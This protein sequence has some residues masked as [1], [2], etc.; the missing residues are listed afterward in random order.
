MWWG[1]TGGRR[2]LFEPEHH[3]RHRQLKDLYDR[4]ARCI[5]AQDAD[6]QPP[7]NSDQK[8]FSAS[9]VLEARR[10]SGCSSSAEDDDRSSIVHAV[11]PTRHDYGNLCMESMYVLCC[12]KRTKG[13]AMSAFT[14]A[15]QWS[16]S[17]VQDLQFDF[18]HQQIQSKLVWKL[19]YKKTRD[20]CCRVRNDH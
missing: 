16:I 18:Y 10:D 5:R 17:F 19:G 15:F 20:I 7:C 6:A 3:Y 1:R 8:D 9:S 13:V 2:E 11:G 12:I 14:H 4:R